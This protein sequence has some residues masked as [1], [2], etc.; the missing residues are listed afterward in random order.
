MGYLHSKAWKSSP[1]NIGITVFL[2]ASTKPSGEP[3]RKKSDT[4]KSNFPKE[5][6]SS[7]VLLLDLRDAESFRKTLE[8]KLEGQH[9]NK[10]FF[11]A[12]SAVKQRNLC[13]KSSRTL[14]TPG[15]E[16]LVLLYCV[17][18]VSGGVTSLAWQLPLG[19]VICSGARN[20]NVTPTEVAAA[21]QRW[22]CWSLSTVDNYARREEVLVLCGQFINVL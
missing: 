22:R 9:K 18:F 16:S 19:L 20:I 1:S 15:Q 5:P 10:S 7:I 21:L 14:N 3:K 6:P 12:N 2:R 13:W 17:Q 4:S 11:R 8:C